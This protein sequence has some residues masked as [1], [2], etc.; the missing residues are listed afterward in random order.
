MFILYKKK[1]KQKIKKKSEKREALCFAPFC[2]EGN[3]RGSNTLDLNYNVI[4][5]IK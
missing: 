1:E 3:K 2:E 5:N 4:E